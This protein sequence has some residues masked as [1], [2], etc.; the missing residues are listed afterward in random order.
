MLDKRDPENLVKAAQTAELLLQDLRELVKSENPLVADI[1][2]E[3]LE[4]ATAI[5]KRL[6]RIS[7]VSR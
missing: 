6:K 7:S 4:S 3:M 5:E 1:A 2:L